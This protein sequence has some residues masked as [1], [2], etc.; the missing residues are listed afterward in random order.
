MK[1]VI[2]KNHEKMAKAALIQYLL[3]K[4]TISDDVVIVNEL[5]LESFSRR[6]DLALVNGSIE[7]FEIK[8][9]ADT[10]TR[11]PGQVETFS[12]FC[13]KLHVVGAQCHIEGILSSTPEH[14]AVWQFDN[15]K[16]IKI[17]RRGSKTLLRDKKSLIK[18]VNVQELRQL[19]TAH[20]IKVSSP[21]RKYLE[22]AAQQ[23]TAEKLRL[24][25]LQALKDRYAYT[26]AQFINAVSERSVTSAHIAA[27]KRKKADSLVTTDNDYPMDDD[28]YMRQ[29]ACEVKDTLFGSPPEDVKML[30]RSA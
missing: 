10:L 1:P 16:G 30:L 26:T 6:A 3:H 22:A 17:I 11:L 20:K 21:R 5:A 12:R 25:V 8:S 4:G 24:G 18:L 7:L 2:E 28:I 23:L 14:V 9:E 15:E 13:D 27:L 29:L 19:L